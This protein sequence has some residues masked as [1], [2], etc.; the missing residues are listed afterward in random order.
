MRDLLPAEVGR[1]AVHSLPRVWGCLPAAGGH[2]RQLVPA[3]HHGARKQVGLVIILK[4]C[5]VSKSN[6]RVHFLTFAFQGQEEGEGQC[7]EC[8]K[9]ELVL[10]EDMTEEDLIRAEEE[11]S[12][13][14]VA[15][16][17]GDNASNCPVC[18]EEFLQTGKGQIS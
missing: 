5:A 9:Q 3:G 1:S 11:I 10:V 17:D 16:R 8:S 4:T 2:P 15:V 13:S 12:P 7:Q 6:C 14:T 18:R